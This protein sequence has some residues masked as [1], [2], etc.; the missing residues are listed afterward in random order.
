MDY[1][2]WISINVAIISTIFFL[3]RLYEFYLDRR[4]N[5]KITTSCAYQLP[6]YGGINVGEFEDFLVVTITNFSKN[7]HQIEIP[8]FT[9]D[10]KVD[11]EQH[12][13]FLDLNTKENYPIALEPGDKHLYMVHYKAVTSDAKNQGITKIKAI[14]ID[15]SGKKYSSKWYKI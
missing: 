9:A 15:T 1:K 14:V 10:K 3:W 6:I 11:G 13:N 2:F 12:F 4:G 7:K 8:R 5:L